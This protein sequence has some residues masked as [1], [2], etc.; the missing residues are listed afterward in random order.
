LTAARVAPFALLLL[1]AAACSPVV[2]HERLG[3]RRYAER[4]FVDALAEY[5]LAM[6]QRVPSAELRAKFAEAALQAGALGEAVTAYHDLARAE[7]AAVDEAADGLTRAARLAIGARD[8]TA[9]ADALVAL[10]DVAPQRPVGFLAVTLGAGTAYVRRP[11]AMD[12]LLEAAAA[13][14]TPADADSFLVAY[15]DLNAR[16]GRC[17]AAT[18]TYEAVLRRSRQVPPLVE[19]AR[20]GLAGCSVENGKASLSAGALQDAE[21]SFRKAIAIG[22][23]D[24]VV[25]LAWL[26]V[27]DTRW[28]EGDTAVAQDAYR[29]AMS[30]ASEGDPI[31]ARANDQLARLLGKGTPTP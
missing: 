31:A 16:M 11:D 19:A 28:A 6:H 10:R 18:R 5:R 23:P 30:G 9:L 27:G 12:V 8:M 20:G 29:R 25:R 14:S 1:L 24:S 15:A 21:V 13:A 7:P 3:D 17:D 2:D 26:L 4:A 22:E